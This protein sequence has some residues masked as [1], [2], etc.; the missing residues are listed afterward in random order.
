M[1]LEKVP[2]SLRGELTRWTLEL[3]AGVFVGTVSATVRDLLWEKIAK[4]LR[5]GGAM[6]IHSSNCEQGFKVRYA[7]DTS[8]TFVDFEGLWLVGIEEKLG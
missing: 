4:S 8:R 6:M 5:S 7:G 1:V 2:T 3:K